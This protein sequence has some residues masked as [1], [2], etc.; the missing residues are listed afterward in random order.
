DEVYEDFVFE[1]EH[2][3]ALSVAPT[4]RTI[5]V[6]GFSKSFAMT[7]W[8]IGYLV[9]P[10]PIAALAGAI[11]EPVTSCPSAP[12]QA[13][14]EAALAADSSVVRSFCEIY[15]RRRAI[16]TEVFAGN[17]ALPVVP[18]GAFYAFIDISAAK[19]TSLPFAKRLLRE[20]AVAAVPGV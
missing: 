13:A 2:V 3:S 17:E 14:A 12:S 1:G 18:E 19:E 4:D 8:R 11:Q 7:G 9:C 15:K 5:V 6:S 10:P 20:H 16:L